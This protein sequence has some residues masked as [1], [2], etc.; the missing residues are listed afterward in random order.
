M[1]NES[2]QNSRFDA[3]ASLD[4]TVLAGGFCV[5]CGAC[6][7]LPNGTYR[8][9]Y[10]EDHNYRAA[11]SQPG[12]DTHAAQVCPFSSEATNETEIAAALYPNCHTDERLG[13]YLGT[14]AGHAK[15]GGIRERGSSGGLTT[16]VAQQLLSRKLV[17]AV[18]HVH[19][20]LP[21]DQTESRVL[22]KYGLSWNEDQLTTNA[23]TRYYPIEMSEVIR[24]IRATPSI[25]VAFVGVP[26]FVKAVRLLCRHDE[27]LN[28]KIAYCISLVCGH[29]KSSRWADLA[30]WQC[31]VPPAELKSIDFRKK[32][33][34]RPANSYGVEINSP[35]D[36]ESAGRVRPVSELF[37]NSWAYMLFAYKACDYCD[38]I[39]GE[40]AD[41]S[42]GDAW[43]P[44]H[45]LDYRG[46]N[47]VVTR[48]PQIEAILQDGVAS[49]AIELEKVN[50]D[51]V[52]HTQRGN[53]R[54]RHEGLAFRLYEAQLLGQWTPPK[55]IQPSQDHLT[56]ERREVFRLRTA[57]RERSH[58]AFREAVRQNNLKY[59]IRQM[60]PLTYAHDKLTIGG[61]AIRAVR[62]AIRI[63]KKAVGYG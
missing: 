31:G 18:A 49:G 15:L 23:K 60:K 53:L 12:R 24:E 58:I 37:G 33:P 6:A 62:K 9:E 17:D 5:G 8:M 22:Y 35:Q 50:I 3:N 47:V 63:L 28:Q 29:L 42:V 1:T 51:Q 48:H 25:R 26:C 59:F 40:T 45:N 41:L 10:T 54:H 36:H 7:S 11:R 19:G 39:L 32:I 4:L 30:A 46:T 21:A 34:G 61:V 13:K 2:P 14:Y 20:P 43:L 52:A 55:R 16:W 27:D 57:M 38:D 44:P 56:N